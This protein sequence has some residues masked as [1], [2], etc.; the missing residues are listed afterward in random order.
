MLPQMKLIIRITNYIQDD[1]GCTGFLANDVDSYSKELHHIFSLPAA[2]RDKIVQKAKL[3]CE[4]FSEEHFEKTF[5]TSI[6][7]LF[8]ES[9]KNR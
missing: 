9:A 8:G 2:E 6:S 7:H 4:R 1:D 3:S 5:L